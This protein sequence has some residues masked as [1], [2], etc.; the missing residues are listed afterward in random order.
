MVEEEFAM[1][2]ILYMYIY[3]YDMLICIDNTHHV[4]MTMYDVLPISMLKTVDI[5]I[6]IHVYG[7]IVTLRFVKTMLHGLICS[8]STLKYICLCSFQ[9]SCSCIVHTCLLISYIY[10]YIHLTLCGYM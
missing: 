8:V 4:I 7:F 3:I 6:Y 2:C 5:Y 9:L 10:I 1:L